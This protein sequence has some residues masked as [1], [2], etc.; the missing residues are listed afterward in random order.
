MASPAAAAGAGKYVFEGDYLTRG[1][2]DVNDGNGRAR[3]AGARGR[4]VRFQMADAR[5]VGTATG[6]ARG[7]AVEVVARLKRRLRPGSAVPAQRVRVLAP[8]ADVRPPAGAPLMPPPAGGPSPPP[9]GAT[10]P[11][12]IEQPPP[13]AEPPPPADPIR[14][15]A[16]LRGFDTGAPG[17]LPEADSVRDLREAAALGAGAVRVVVN[18]DWLE[19]YAQDSFNDAQLAVTD[20]LLAVADSEAL[21]VIVTVLG[22]PCWATSAPRADDGTCDPTARAHPPADPADYGTFLS[23]L[24]DRWGA[25]ID[26]IEVWNE[27]NLDAFWHGSVGDYVDLVQSADEAVPDGGPKVLAGAL[28]GSDDAYLQRLYDA[29]VDR[30]SDGI[31]IHPYAIA[32]GGPA[33]GFLDPL[34]S[35]PGAFATFT[36]GVPAIHD[37]M[38]ANGDDDGLWL[39]EFGYAD[40]PGVPYCV[41]AEA[42]AEY[43]ASAFELAAQWP[44]V[45]AMLVYRL[46][47][48]FDPED[49][50]TSWIGDGSFEYRFGVLNRDW[51]PKPAADR[52][53]RTLRQLA[54]R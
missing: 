33:A 29:G 8:E 16:Q 45:K 7:D 49:P 10:P 28:S 46:R 9:G 18:W 43:L 52:L 38:V 23:L 20:R 5:L 40:C 48:W 27:P 22:T 44:Y 39:T 12:P 32:W 2:V 54:G 31:S 26:A 35:Y 11:P 37:R 42:Q 19:P 3:Q 21:S 30:F 1:K 53:Q 13:P 15:A 36:W 25:K 41:N 24:N 17:V 4:V 6:P 47:D 14:P 51:S 50:I 34:L